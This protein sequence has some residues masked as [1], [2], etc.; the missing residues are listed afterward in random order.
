MPIVGDACHHDTAERSAVRAARVEF[1][2]N[3]GV[4]IARCLLCLAACLIACQETVAYGFQNVGGSGS[5]VYYLATRRFSIPFDLGGGRLPS[6]IQLE[7]SVDGGRTWNYHAKQPVSRAGRGRQSFDFESN[8][9]GTI[10]FRLRSLDDYGNA[11]P[12]EAPLMTIVVDTDA[13]TADMDIL[14]DPTGQILASFQILDSNADPTTVRLEVAE[15]GSSRWRPVEVQLTERQSTRIRGQAVLEVP[16]NIRRIMVRLYGTDRS[17]NPF[18]IIRS[19]ELPR[20]ANR[21][22][23]RFASQLQEA[24]PDNVQYL[25]PPNQGELQVFPSDGRGGSNFNNRSSSMALP[26]TTSPSQ[27]TRDGKYVLQQMP[28]GSQLDS[29]GLLPFPHGHR[30]PTGPGL[31]VSEP[32]PKSLPELPFRVEPFYSHSRAFSLDYSLEEELQGS[33]ASIELWGTV[34]RGKTWEYW[35]K[36][37]D[38]QS[39]FD[40]QVDEDGLFGFRMVITTRQG[41]S[42]NA[43]RSG[44]EADVWVQVDTQAPVTRITSAMYGK[45]EET[46]SLIIEY[47]CSDEWL[48][49]RPIQ[50][51]FAEYPQGPWS[52]I[53][54]GLPNQGRY[55]WRADPNLPRKIYLRI[56]TVDLAGNIGTHVTDIP[57]DMQGL[58][59]RGRFQG[60]RPIEIPGGR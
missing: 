4:G 16:I 51:S 29:E 53:A 27:L 41:I 35:D 17:G 46:G 20:V 7:Y 15:E 25:P 23:M 56:D 28:S 30:Q 39:P 13:P 21:G 26:P 8:A 11:F 52:T 59:P 5:D 3:R 6:E 9:D 19:P 45:G 43:P 14:L 37:P 49:N 58:A 24:V 34:D 2:A 31:S 60:V 54:A 12:S 36:D 18:E 47:Q 22:G 48:G 38:N 50:L 1:F 57:I 42:G 40:I 32:R 55:A 10:S 33:I 44:D